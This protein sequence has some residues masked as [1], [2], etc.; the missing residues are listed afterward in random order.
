MD[1]IILAIIAVFVALRLRS[2]LGKISEEEKD[3][4]SEKIN[5]KSKIQTSYNIK[6]TQENRPPENNIIVINHDDKYLENLDEKNK[7]SVIAIMNKCSITLDFFITGAKSAFEMVIE[8]F[9]K[10]NFENLE[11]LLSEKVFQEF[12]KSIEERRSLQK[13]LN[14]NLIAIENIEIVNALLD[15]N[16]AYIT[17]KIK[18]KQINYITNFNSEVIEGNKSNISQ[19]TDIWTFRRDIDSTNPNWKIS[20]TS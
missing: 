7:T 6:P 10:E 11:M 8:S 3:N 13:I 17:L 5:Q 2:E 16:Q 19:L 9:A 4:I 14:T 20:A 18:S 12:K 15:H 1:L